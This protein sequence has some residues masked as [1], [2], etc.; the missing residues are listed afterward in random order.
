MPMWGFAQEFG[1]ECL[2][3]FFDNLNIQLLIIIWMKEVLLLQIHSN[4]NDVKQKR[5][6]AM[7]SSPHIFWFWN[8]FRACPIFMVN[9]SHNKFTYMACVL[10]SINYVGSKSISKIIHVSNGQT[11]VDLVFCLQWLFF[12]SWTAKWCIGCRTK[13]TLVLVIF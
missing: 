12:L 11:R 6:P 13:W 5:L 10:D 9:S 2:P 1:E 3:S 7:C 8:I 4:K